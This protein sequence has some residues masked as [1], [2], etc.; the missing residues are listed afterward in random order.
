V[1]GD[2]YSDIIVGAFGVDKA[3]VFHGSGAGLS[4]SA[5][6]TAES[7]Q[8]GAWFGVSVGTAG[9][10]NGDGYSDVIV[11]ASYYEDFGGVFVYY[12]SAKGLSMSADWTASGL[13]D[14][15][16][17]G[18]SVGTAGDVNNDGISDVIV[19]AYGEN[20]VYVFHGSDSD[21]GMSTT[22]DWTADFADWEASGEA[23]ANFGG[24]VGTAGDV[25]GD[26]ISDVIV[27]AYGENKVYVFHGIFHD[28]DLDAGMS[29][30][31]DWTTESDQSD[32]RFGIGVGT[33]GDVNG[34]EISDVIVGAPMYNN[35]ET[36]DDGGRAFA[37]YGSSDS[38]CFIATAAY[39]SPMEPH[40]KILRAFRDRILLVNA[41]GRGFVRLYYKYSPPIA[42]FIANHDSLRTIVRVSLLPVV[43]VSWI[44][45][46]MGFVAT[47]ALMFFLV[48]GL[49]GI[50]GFRKYKK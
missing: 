7:D 42:N 11:G 9:D 47:M 27:G 25:N 19:G 43:G 18:R 32:A 17:F 40:V 1:N 26:G 29:T 3:Y 37:Y 13:S 34:D 46:K 35:S 45:L 10:V 16:S 6:W 39:G 20:K 44:A 49:I 50:I 30:T 22:A 36:I 15:A 33:A 28:S 41:I 38:I 48:A 14:Y 31:A 5:D 8:A 12:G 2:G 4:V 21:A 23:G 24:S